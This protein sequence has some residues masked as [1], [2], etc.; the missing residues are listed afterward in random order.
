MPDPDDLDT[1]E[2]KPIRTVT[3][4]QMRTAEQDQ[5]VFH[6]HI[7]PHVQRPLRAGVLNA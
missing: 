7:G 4:D 3:S 2:R 1:A 6:R 5:A